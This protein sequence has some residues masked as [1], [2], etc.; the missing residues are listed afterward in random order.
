MI[1]G[2]LFAS[3]SASATVVGEAHRTAYD[4][5]AVLRDSAQSPA[6]RITVWYPAAQGSTDT[7]L[8]IGP[9]GKPFFNVAR[10]APDAAFEPGVKNFPI[11]LLSHGFGGSA[12]IM[13]WFGVALARAGY[14]V[15]AVDH[16][17]NNTIDR[18]TLP[19]AVL[20]WDRAEDL[21]IALRAVEL[22]PVLGPHVDAGRVGAA[23][24]SAG[25]FTALVLGGAR[26]SQ[27]HFLAFCDAHPADGVCMPQQEF[28][29]G[30][31]AI[32][33]AFRDPALSA[34]A[35]HAGDDHSVPGLKAVFAM[36]PALIQALDPGSLGRMRIPVE[37]V[38]GDA[39]RV[40]PPATNG[41]VAVAA[42]Q[43]AHVQRFAGVGHYDF[44][45]DCTDAGRAIV[46]ACKGISVPQE[47]T[48]GRAIAAAAAFFDAHLGVSSGV[49]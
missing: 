37:V 46:P 32:P 48:H 14:V 42:I 40:A 1:L 30:A 38:L 24:F 12:R 29:V 3:G 49:R 28:P 27:S 16:P 11:I 19:G 47:S 5:T 23:G 15:I 9:P 36:A 21:R 10:V 8:V 41:L 4:S 34:E 33:A 18:M 6:L 17:G 44:L 20:W 26:V 39:D 45:A 43:G 35:A 7:A 13:G 2:A 22:D 31:N 25:G